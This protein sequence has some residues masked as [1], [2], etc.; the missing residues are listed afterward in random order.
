MRAGWRLALAG[1][2]GAVV[3]VAALAGWAPASGD[4]PGYFVPLRQRTAE[5]LR[6]SRGP[7]WD[8]DVGCGE[9]YFANPQ[10]TLLYPLAW[11]GLIAPA[12]MAVGIEAGVHLAVLGVG[13]AL[14]ARRL[15]AGGWLEVGAA[16]SV[17]AAGPV[18]DAVPVLNNADALAWMPWVWWAALGGSVPG[19]A[20]FLA[21]AYLAAEPQLALVAG[22]VAATL[23]PRRRTLAAIAL[24]VGLV[25]VQ[26]VPFAAWV[27]N[28]DRGPHQEAQEGLAGV[29]T[30]ADL[31]TALA[32]GAP[33]PPR[34]G[35]RFVA[36]LALPLWAVVLGAV[37][38]FDRRREVRRLAWW[39]WGLTALAALPWLPGGLAA[40][41]V[42]TGGLIRYS[43]RL[44]FPAVVALV[45][46]AAAAVG[47]R[48]PGIRLCV[49]LAAIAVAGGLALRGRPLP[50]V[51]GGVAA[52]AV[53]APAV[54][55]PA[56]LAG[57]AA[58]AWQAEG[59]LQI[60]AVRDRRPVVCL[61]AQRS[62][63]R[64]YVVAPSWE[65]FRWLGRHPAI[66]LDSLGLGYGALLD[67]R[68]M[69]RTFAPLGPRALAA[70][71]READKGP[72]GRWWLDALAARRVVAQHPI[73]GLP[74]LCRQGDFVVYDNPL[75][76]P[77]VSIVRALP[78]PGE[79][80]SACGRV[81]VIED[82][83][84]RRVWRA[85]V[86][87]GGGVFL[88]L[89]SPDP[90]WQLRVD[91]R[92]VREVAG[93][94]ILHGVAVPAGDHRITARYRPPGLVAGAAV[95]LASVVLLAGIAWRRS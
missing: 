92:P 33:L 35:A 79:A 86:E 21:L 74:E 68:R 3:A 19:A 17:I 80:P 69:V 43:G 54:A 83:D 12:P 85:H 29:V 5:V 18:L 34:I 14:L 87:A 52:G 81:Q 45:P 39:G 65:Q 70:Q 78:S 37:A 38:A 67:G 25:A 13:C 40:W 51:V 9:P 24:A 82:H 75:A 61:E 57:V 2:P 49:S 48:R 59:A 55:A 11:F 46:A 53:L 76:W 31:L 47:T 26:A 60:S 36:N 16:W 28:G 27:R 56:M 44:L 7:F 63:G 23:A 72:E 20:S 89:E 41:N 66:G 4:L 88:W 1:L 50:T 10:T 22:L 58:V 91:D 93:V 15:G 90:G 6:G 95:S 30:P 62:A 32:P 77:E 71:L 73:A 64:V 42:I 84:D 94:G 8:P